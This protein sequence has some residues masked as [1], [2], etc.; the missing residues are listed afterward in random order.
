MII[1]SKTL[2]LPRHR[3]D[4]TRRGRC[5][6]HRGAQLRQRQ[7]HCADRRRRYG[8][9]FRGQRR[10]GDF[11][12]F[13]VDRPDRDRRRADTFVGYSGG[14]DGFVDNAS[15]FNGVTIRNFVASD[16]IEVSNLAFAGRSW[17]FRPMGRIPW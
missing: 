11:V 9:R 13:V 10:V 4:Q 5:A 12:Q 1:L 2:R 7:H 3:T 8:P 16:F 14:S 15:A 17:R 6:H